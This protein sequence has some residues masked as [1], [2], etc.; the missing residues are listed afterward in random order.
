MPRRSPQQGKQNPC[1]PNPP[2]PEDLAF[3]MYTSGTT[4][5]PKGV[6]LKHSNVIATMSGVMGS[7]FTL[8]DKDVFASYLPLAHILQRASESC[9]FSFGGAIG[10]WRGDIKLLMEDL[11]VSSSILLQ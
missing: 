7:F 10:Y 9:F 4:G 6:P 8:T 5:M 3:I 11:M 1:E 2:N